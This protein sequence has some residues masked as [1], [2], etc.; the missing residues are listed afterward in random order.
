MA[1]INIIG[2][3]ELING[4]GKYTDELTATISK[5]T[6]ELSEK[7]ANELKTIRKPSGS[8]GTATN[9]TGRREWNKYSKS[10]AVNVQGASD[11]V[12][13]TIHNKKHYQ[14]THL[15]EYGHATRNG[16]RTRAF[17]HIKQVSDKLEET[18]EKEIEEVIKK[19]G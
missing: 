5:K 10:W 2:A 4:L 3:E 8:G 9:D 12:K 15:L 18:Y 13:C 14:L 1:N 19:G 11:Y 7:G 17:P 6:V 16:K